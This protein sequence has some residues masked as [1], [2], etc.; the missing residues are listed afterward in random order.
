LGGISSRAFNK[1]R[2]AVIVGSLDTT[3]TLEVIVSTGFDL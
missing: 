3:L 2:A 1:S